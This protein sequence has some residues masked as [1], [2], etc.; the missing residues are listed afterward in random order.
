MLV[1]HFLINTKCL[2]CAN[3]SKYSIRNTFVFLSFIHF[4]LTP[5]RI[6]LKKKKKEENPVCGVGEILCT[7]RMLNLPVLAVPPLPPAPCP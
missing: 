7:E 2:L 5:S 6:R 1:F 4:L 3:L